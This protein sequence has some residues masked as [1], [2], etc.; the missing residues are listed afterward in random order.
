MLLAENC[1]I[2]DRRVGADRT[3]DYDR[4]DGAFASSG[5]PGRRRRCRVRQ[6]PRARQ[7]RRG[8]SGLVATPASPLPARASRGAA[9]GAYCSGSSR[10]CP[11]PPP[12]LAPPLSCGYEPAWR[13]QSRAEAAGAKPPDRDA[14][15]ATPRPALAG[16]VIGCRLAPTPHNAGDGF[17]LD[18]QCG[19]CITGTD[20]RRRAWSKATGVHGVTE[21]GG[22]RGVPPCGSHVRPRLQDAGTRIRA[23][24]RGDGSVE[25]G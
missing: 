4:S 23:D 1:R 19:A 9:F 6:S 3:Q 21:C 2:H 12:P 22:M 14:A 7:R 24:Q 18:Q 11:V 20:H 16:R 13:W 5:D 8:S 17:Y 15:L 10:G 25:G